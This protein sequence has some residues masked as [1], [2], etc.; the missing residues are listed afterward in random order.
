MNE[1]YKSMQDNQVWDLVPLPK[2]KKPIDCKWIFKTK[3]NSEGNME[4]YK[5]RLVAKDF[6]QREDIDFMGHFLSG[7]IERLF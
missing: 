2:D 4:R 7:F 1:E 6:T 3:R 5:A